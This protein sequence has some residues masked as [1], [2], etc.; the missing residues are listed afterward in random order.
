MTTCIM[1]LPGEAEP[2][3]PGK[4][5]LL[6]AKA[7]VR[8]L[9]FPSTFFWELCGSLQHL[10]RAASFRIYVGINHS[11]Y[12]L[13]EILEGKDADS[14]GPRGLKLHS[15]QLRAVGRVSK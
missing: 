9:Y 14:L 8:A 3:F 15:A 11:P 2:G 5:V 6:E 12:H 1:P 13:T 10:H 7:W 4:E